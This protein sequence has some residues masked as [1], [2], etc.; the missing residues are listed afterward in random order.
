[1]LPEK[2]VP[3]AVIWTVCRWCLDCAAGPEESSTSEVQRLQKFCR[4]IGRN[5]WVF[6]VPP[7]SVVGRICK[8]YEWYDQRIGNWKM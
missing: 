2:D 1:M 7:K 6:A 4:R 3:S 5:C 8:R